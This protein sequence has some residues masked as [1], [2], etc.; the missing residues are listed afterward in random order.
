M[1]T[2]EMNRN[3]LPACVLILALVAVGLSGPLYAA[4]PADLPPRDQPS[5]SEVRPSKLP[6]VGFID[7]H[8]DP[9]QTGLWAVVQWQDA[10]GDWHDV[11]GWR[12]ALDSGYQQ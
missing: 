10:V 3:I 8:V 4:P 9:A 11:E 6:L 5:K 1:S 7:L 12:G 2:R